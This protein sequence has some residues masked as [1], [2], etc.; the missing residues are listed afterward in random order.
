MV[1]S[2]LLEKRQPLATGRSRDC[3]IVFDPAP[4]KTAALQV[5]G[6]DE[7]QPSFVETLILCDQVW[8]EL[9]EGPDHVGEQQRFLRIEFTEFGL[10]RI[11]RLLVSCHRALRAGVGKAAIETGLEGTCGA[12]ALGKLQAVGQFHGLGL[13]QSPLE[14]GRGLL[15]DCGPSR[16]T[17]AQR[18]EDQHR[19][20]DQGSE[21]RP[22]DDL[23]VSGS[24]TIFLHDVCPP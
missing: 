21:L 14:T 23:T 18:G 3:L 4:L 24:R 17:R 2:F 13:R 22:P 5:S 10:F 15:F 11:S 20:G 7:T 19:Q 12:A 6:S 16:N 1:R 8:Q 9:E